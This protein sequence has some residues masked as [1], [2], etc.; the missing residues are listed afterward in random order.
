VLQRNLYTLGFAPAGGRGRDHKPPKDWA[1]KQLMGERK[2]VAIDE[3]DLF[4][5]CGIVF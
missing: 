2:I 5:A 4:D 1:N 3:N